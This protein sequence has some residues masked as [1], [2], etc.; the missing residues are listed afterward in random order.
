MR[1]LA[2]LAGLVA[3]YPIRR[4]AAALAWPEVS[5]ERVEADLAEALREGNR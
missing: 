5:L 4:L 2:A 1:R 3:L